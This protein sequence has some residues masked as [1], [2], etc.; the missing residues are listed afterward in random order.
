MATARLHARRFLMLLLA[1]VLVA[2]GGSSEVSVNSGSGTGTGT[3]TPG[4]GALVVSVSGLPQGTGGDL[5]VTGPNGFRQRVATSTTL[6]GLVPGTYTVVA[7]NVLTGSTTLSPQPVTQQVAVGSGTSSVAVTYS[8]AAAFALALREVV[9]GLAAPVHLTAPP[10]DSRLFVVERAGRVRIV[11]NGALLPTPFLDISALTTADGERGLL[12]MDFDPGYAANGRFYLYYTD[13]GGNIVIA[14][15]Q[16]SAAD[17][18]LAGTTGAIVLTIPHPDFN[19]HNGGLLAFGPDGMLYLGVGD[20]GGE[21]DPSGHAQDPGTLLGKL[22][23]IDVSNSGAQPYAIP[24]GNPFVGQAGRRGEIWA[25]G[26]RNPWRFAFDP[27]AGN[28]YIADVGQDQREE[29]DVEPAASGGLNY[30]WNVTEGTMCFLAA[31]CN[32]QGLTLPQ[33]EYDH[34][35]SGGCAV[36]GAYVYRGNAM[37]ALR[38]RYLYS[39]LCSGWLRSFAFR[40]GVT[41]KLDWGIAAPGSVLSFGMDGQGELYLLADTFASGTS[42]KVFRIVDRSAP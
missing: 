27:A 35:P 30:G 40:D 23:R 31:S 2:C 9:T 42:G 36:I 20:G 39:D 17:P 37:P 38:G 12:S 11:Q 19:N 28:L 6:T 4:R 8:A 25:T 21:G 34:G 7:G 22:L 1:L 16:V 29:I 24:P 26:L 5:T 13:L 10:N 33:L 14:R 3:G 32:T 18:N 15:Y 41:E